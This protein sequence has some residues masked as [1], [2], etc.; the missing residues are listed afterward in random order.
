M[1][2]AVVAAV[3]FVFLVGLPL[4]GVAVLLYSLYRVATSLGDEA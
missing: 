3:G 2:S 1:L 4:F